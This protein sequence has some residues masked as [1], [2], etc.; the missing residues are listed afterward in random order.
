LA[1]VTDY[2]DALLVI[3]SVAGVKVMRPAV[4]AGMSDVSAVAVTVYVTSEKEFEE[5]VPLAVPVITKVIC[6]ADAMEKGRN[7]A[8]N[9]EIAKAVNFIDSILL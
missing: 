9:M 1:T 8:P 3:V 7:A 5:I 6:A 2:D 4:G